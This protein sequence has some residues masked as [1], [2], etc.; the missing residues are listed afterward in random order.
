MKAIKVHLA[1][2]DVIEAIGRGD[3]VME[4]ATPKGFQRGVLKDVWFIPR[5]SRN[6]FSVSQ[7]TTQD[8][9]V[10]FEKNLCVMEKK[11]MKLAIGERFGKGLYKLKMAPVEP[12][13]AM[14]NLSEAKINLSKLWHE[15]LGHIGSQ[16]LEALVK[17]KM[18]SDMPL[19]TVADWGFG[20][21]T[22]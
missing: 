19:K 14:A 20:G 17:N 5:L 3:I 10:S 4:L 16:G 13:N 22:I 9:T 12:A 15:R 11:G 7:F 18:S 6:L 21:S 1:D 8:S 2:N